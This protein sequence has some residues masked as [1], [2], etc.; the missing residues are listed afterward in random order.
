MVDPSL[1][2]MSSRVEAEATD[3][4]RNMVSGSKAA[5][6]IVSSDTMS[7]VDLGVAAMMKSVTVI[8][9]T[10]ITMSALGRTRIE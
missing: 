1:G 3:P 7:G 2:T 4:R 9:I 10:T 8:I 5:M 6:D